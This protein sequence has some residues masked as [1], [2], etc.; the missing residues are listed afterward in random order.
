MNSVI[1][2]LT[3]QSYVTRFDMLLGHPIYKKKILVI[4]EGDDDKKVY[5]RMFDK[6]VVDVRS[7]GGCNNF[8]Q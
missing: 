8:Y 3:P 7:I 5:G 2:S 1:A 6:E 4:V